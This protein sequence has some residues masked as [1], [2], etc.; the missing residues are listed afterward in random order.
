MA[1]NYPGLRG[2]PPVHLT[3]MSSQRIQRALK[4]ASVTRRV[5]F[6]AAVVASIALALPR[7]WHMGRSTSLGLQGASKQASGI[8]VTPGVV[9]PTPIPPTRVDSSSS[10]VRLALILT[11]TRPG[12]NSDEGFADI[13]VGAESPQTYAVGSLLANGARLVDIYADSAVLTRDGHSVRIYL[14]HEGRSAG[15]ALTPPASSLAFVGGAAP[16]KDATP[17]SDEPVLDYIRASPLYEGDFLRGYQVYAGS[18]PAV[19]ANTGLQP[20]DV[21]T[22]IDGTP[23][24]SPEIV[25]PQLR[26]LAQGSALTMTVER[27]DAAITLVVDGR[28][29]AEAIEE[30]ATRGMSAASSTM[31]P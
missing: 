25:I 8:G 17:D 24:S 30:K 29:I 9:I 31:A 2:T 4:N 13:G 28:G 16:P 14:R 5:V 26:T 1:G 10:P 3:R 21:I 22:S 15:P 19:F 11:A 12:R 6:G 23:V 27:R 20:G 18:T 7:P